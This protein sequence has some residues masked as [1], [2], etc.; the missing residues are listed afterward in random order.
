MNKEKNKLFDLGF[1]K[2][3]SLNF[4]HIDRLD[5]KMPQI[6]LFLKIKAM[7]REDFQWS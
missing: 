2:E 4:M 1:I 5:D 7:T 3:K 6:D